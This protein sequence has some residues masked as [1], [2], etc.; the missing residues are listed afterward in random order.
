VRRWGRYA[1]LLLASASVACSPGPPPSRAEAL[2]TDYSSYWKFDEASGLT[3]ADASGH[4]NTGTLSATG[5]TFSAGKVNNAISFDGV[6]GHA[7]L[8][9]A[10]LNNLAAWTWQG[11][12]YPTSSTGL[13]YSEGNPAVTFQ[14]GIGGDGAVTVQVWN[15]S[16]VPNN[17]VTSTTTAGLMPAN[18]WNLLT[19]TL[20][21]A[22]VGTGT[23]KVYVN[24]SLAWS[25]S[26]QMESNPASTFA[27]FGYNVGLQA[28]QSAAYWQG[29]L[30]DVTIF[31]RALSPTEIC[32][33]GKL[34]GSKCIVTTSCCTS[35]DCLTPPSV[36][37]KA[38]T[39]PGVGKVCSYPYAQG[40]ACNADSD[41][42]TPNDA[43]NNGVCV[44]DTAHAVVC[45]QLDCHGPPSCNH[46]TGDCESSP[47][48]GSSCGG[49]LCN[50]PGTCAAGACSGS[51]L[52]DCSSGL[53]ACTAGYCDPSTGA[54]ATDNAPNGTA[55]TSNDKCLVN[56][57]CS[58]GL[59]VGDE[60]PCPAQGQ[61]TTGTCNPTSGDCEAMPVADGT[62]C[63]EC[64]A[65]GACTGGS[66]VCSSSPDAGVDAGSAPS[67]GHG[68]AFGA[69]PAGVQGLLALAFALALALAR[70]RRRSS[71]R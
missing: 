50:A 49:N 15:L 61:C 47:I 43:C 37:Y 55:C 28:A 16:Y 8:V 53:A 68:C 17:W 38:G 44:A 62:P 66:C 19:L 29:K 7:D 63:D 40:A 69:G 25:G 59:C 2:A 18:Q 58:G 31:S 22:A 14:L 35:A 48:T 30:D 26:S 10:T 33:T 4:G 39:C 57:A 70:R 64:G 52:K 46:S 24:K 23:L 56:T 6:S 54:C 71:G 41:K 5:A 9:H 32:D 34:C 20:E 21:G 1:A 51:V 45:P 12:V 13:V 27:G 65:L 36:C 11:W 67:S 42:C 60:R 3:A